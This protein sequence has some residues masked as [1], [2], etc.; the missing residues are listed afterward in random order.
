M[1]KIYRVTLTDDARGNL[2]ALIN[3]GKGEARKL[4][5]ARALLPADAAEGG[6][7][8][9]DQTIAGVLHVCARTG[10]RVR[11][12][13]V[14][15]GLEA[16]LIPKPN[17]RVYARLLDGAQEACLIA[18]ACSEP[19]DGK[20]R[21]TLQLLAERMVELDYA[22]TLSDETVR[23]VLKKTNSNRIFGNYALFHPKPRLTLSLTWRISK[24]P[25]P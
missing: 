15:Q 19:P 14:E 24:R 18:L 22:E 8:R 21:W 17:D 4:S 25:G 16:A 5:H 7:R 1:A 11:Q 20:S 9:T 3:R 6:P 13:F 10:E 12:C 2:K 23:R